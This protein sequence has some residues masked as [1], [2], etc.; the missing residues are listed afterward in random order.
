MWTQADGNASL[1]T[2]ASQ[3]QFQSVLVDFGGFFRTALA[4]LFRHAGFFIAAAADAAPYK[5]INLSM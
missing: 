1:F 2:E 4:G 3:G 5:S